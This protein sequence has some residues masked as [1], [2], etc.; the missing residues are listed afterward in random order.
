MGRTCSRSIRGIGEHRASFQNLIFL[1]LPKTHPVF[2]W[3]QFKCDLIPG[4][5]A[6]AFEVYNT[7]TSLIL[8]FT[9]FAPLSS[10]QSSCIS[11]SRPDEVPNVPFHVLDQ[12]GYGFISDLL[13]I[14]SF[15]HSLKDRHSKV[16]KWDI[17]SP[18]SCDLFEDVAL[19]DC[20]FVGGEETALV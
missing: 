15:R 1:P 19:L 16:L 13:K 9:Y 6:E 14:F 5:T 3:I 20:S 18:K 11:T 12:M 7:Q 17:A 2:A 8:L 4:H 10:D